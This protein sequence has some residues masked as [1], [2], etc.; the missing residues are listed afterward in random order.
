MSEPAL[1]PQEAGQGTVAAA[2]PRRLLRDLL[3]SRLALVGLVLFTLIALAAIFAPW[4]SP[5]N[6]Y[7][8]ASLNLLD[9]RLA[10][11]GVGIAGNTYLL[12]SDEQ[13]R[14]MLSAILYGLRISIMVGLLSS[15]FAL[16]LGTALG[17]IAGYLGGRVDSVIMRIVDIQLSIPSILIALILLAVLGRG[18]DKIIIALVTV[19]WV[20]F[21]RTVRSL[22]LVEREKEYVQA[23]RVYGFSRMRILFVHIMPNTLAPVTVVATVEFAHAIALEATLSFLGVGLPLT[24]PSLGLLISNGFAYLLNGE[25]WISIYPGIALLLAVFSLN[26]LGDQ[27]RDLLNPRL[28]K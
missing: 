14:D 21:A 15:V 22:A 8:L 27:L 25:Y 28:Q 5:Q 1:R 12:G 19:Q 17:L 6:P 9:S 7:N 20:Y 18:I 16:L 24:E 3:G 10:P 11:G 26:L 23:A 4:L 2:P 13:G